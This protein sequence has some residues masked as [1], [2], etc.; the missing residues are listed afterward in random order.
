MEE[1]RGSDTRK[2][3]AGYDPAKHKQ[4]VAMPIY[5]TTSL[6][7]GDVARARR[8]NAIAETDTDFVYSRLGI[9]QPKC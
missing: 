9:L 3:Q 7:L 2:V 6:E 1:R 5:Q 4:S 8:L